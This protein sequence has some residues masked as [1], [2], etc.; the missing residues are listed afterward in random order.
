MAVI[1][2]PN[3]SLKSNKTKTFLGVFQSRLPSDYLD[4][5]SL[6]GFGFSIEWS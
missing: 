1:I 2:N 6:F 3:L 5:F 4:A